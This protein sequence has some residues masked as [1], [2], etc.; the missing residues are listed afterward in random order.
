MQYSRLHRLSELQVRVQCLIINTIVM[1]KGAMGTPEECYVSP[2]EL[3]SFPEEVLSK[4]RSFITNA[5]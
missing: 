1:E 3:K 4:L 5:L 2:R